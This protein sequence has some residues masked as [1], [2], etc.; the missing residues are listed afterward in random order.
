MFEVIELIE[1]DPTAFG[2]APAEGSPAPADAIGPVPSVVHHSAVPGVTMGLLA[3]LVAAA[4]VVSALLPLSGAGRSAQVLTFH[5]LRRQL[6]T[7]EGHLVFDVAPGE[8]ATAGLGTV[9]TDGRAVFSGLHDVVGYVFAAPGAHITFNSG[10]SGRVAT[11]WSEPVGASNDSGPIANPATQVQGAPATVDTYGTDT[12]IMFGPVDG[13]MFTLNAYNL[14]REAALRLAEVVAVRDG[15]PAITD[16]RALAGMRPVGSMVEFGATLDV[17]L[18]PGDVAVPT[19]NLVFVRYSSAGD[20][21]GGGDHTLASIPA[22]HETMLPMLHFLFP[23]GRERRV[24]G[25]TALV[26]GDGAAPDLLGSGA[27]TLVAWVEGGRLIVVIGPGDELATLAL[28]DSI[29]PATDD[30]WDE[31]VAAAARTPNPLDSSIATSV[32]LDSGNSRDGEAYSL[33]ATWHGESQ[34]EACVEAATGTVCSSMMGG[35]LPLLLPLHQGRNTFLV[36]VADSSATADQAFLV[37]TFADPTVAPQ[38]HPLVGFGDGLPGPMAGVRVPDGVVAAEL[39][40][41]GAVV[42]TWRLSPPA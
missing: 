35:P 12:M 14:D 5:P 17:V 20:G 28:T 19:A 39:R 9:G 16:D 4:L 37:L 6:P 34:F 11:F 15:V 3:L 31:V 41:D 29:R 32:T 10:Y 40:V 26:V 8:L 30:E 1:F 23:Q 42:A 33:I 7:L 18:T 24:R 38:V 13:R 27:G 36:A 22:A 2:G 21:G 25:T